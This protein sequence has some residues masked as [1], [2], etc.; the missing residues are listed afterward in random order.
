MVKNYCCS[1]NRVDKKYLKKKMLEDDRQEIALEE[2]NERCTTFYTVKY[3]PEL[4]ERV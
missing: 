3:T 4:M 1:K 2:H